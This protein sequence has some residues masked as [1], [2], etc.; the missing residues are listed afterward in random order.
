M[1]VAVY[2]LN[3]SSFFS[4]WNYQMQTNKLGLRHGYSEREAS[5]S[6]Q[7]F[8]KSITSHLSK[9]IYVWKGLNRSWPNRAHSFPHLLQACDQC[10]WLQL[11]PDDVQLF[12][13][14]PWHPKLL[15]SHRFYRSL[16]TDMEQN[17][18]TTEQ[19]CM[20]YSS[21]TLWSLL[22]RLFSCSVGKLEDPSR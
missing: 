4:A 3:S 20:F 17:R 8:D 15:C 9:T 10:L 12:R 16:C 1:P 5:L 6:R 19:L 22:Q 13:I 14:S 7:L 21:V 18:V 2:P 11:K